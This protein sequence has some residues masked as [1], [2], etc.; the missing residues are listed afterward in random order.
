MI[1]ILKSVQWFLTRRLLNIYLDIGKIYI[2]NI[3]PD[4]SWPCFLT[5][6]DDL[7]NLDR[8]S[9][10]E[11]ICQIILQLVKWFLTRTFFKVFYIGIYRK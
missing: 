1:L 7:N 9:S 11:H 4:P 3:N 10:M 2:G 6:P 5:N 8:G